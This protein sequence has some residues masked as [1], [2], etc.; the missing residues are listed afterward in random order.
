MML[1]K[2]AVMNPT[3]DPSHQPMAPPTLTHKKERRPFIVK[4]PFE[5][6]MISSI[7]IVSMVG[8]N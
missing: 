2:T 1:R 5:E 7:E 6:T 3:K 8:A 4:D